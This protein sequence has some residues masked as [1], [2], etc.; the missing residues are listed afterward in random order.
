MDDT[1]IK[2]FT[3]AFKRIKEKEGENRGVQGEIECPA[4]KGKLRYTIARV[5]GHIWGTCETKGCLSW[6]Q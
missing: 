1:Y 5:N 6:M 4:C 3:E 2:N